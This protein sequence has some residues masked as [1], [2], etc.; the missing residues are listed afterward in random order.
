[1]K[2]IH[3]KEYYESKEKLRIAGDTFPREVSEYSLVKYC[4]FP[5]L[6]EDDE[7]KMVSFKPKDKITI[8]WEHYNSMSIIKSFKVSNSENGEIEYKPVWNQKKVHKWIEN[9]T[10]KNSQ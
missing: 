7:K 3:F 6:T 1:M 5:V 9:S 2:K 8:L 10:R 4:K